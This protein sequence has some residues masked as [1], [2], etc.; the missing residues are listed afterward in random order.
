MVKL[1][2]ANLE[3]R[4]KLELDAMIHGVVD[5]GDELLP[6]QRHIANH[7]IG[8]LRPCRHDLWRRDVFLGAEKRVQ[9]WVYVVQEGAEKRVQSWVYVVQ[10]V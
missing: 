2:H 8:A 6:C 4:V 5:H 3:L 1:S 9:S 7:A 10:E